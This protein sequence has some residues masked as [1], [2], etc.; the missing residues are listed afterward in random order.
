MKLNLES[1]RNSKFEIDHNQLGLILG[2]AA[3]NTYGGSKVLAAGTPQE[4][5]ITW[6]TDTTTA[7]GGE[8]YHQHGTERDLMEV[9]PDIT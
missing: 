7:T 6:S 3:P 2:G 4:T 1:L 9:V 5:T 8:V